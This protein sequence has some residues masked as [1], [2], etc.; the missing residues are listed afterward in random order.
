[1]QWNILYSEAIENIAEFLKTHLADVVCLQEMT[2]NYDKQ[3]F[4]HTPHYIAAQLGYHVYFQEITFM[5]KSMKLA[6]A[7][8]SKYPLS[9][10][11][12]VWI[13]KEQGSD[14]FDD[15]NR[16]YIQA[17]IDI[18]GKKITVGTVHMS[19]THEFKPTK[20]KLAEASKLTKAIE[21]T[22]TAFILTGDFNATPES[23]VINR[24]ERQLKNCGPEYTEKTWT[25][26]PFTYGGVNATTLDWRLDYI[27][28]SKDLKVDTTKVLQTEYSDHLPVYTNFS[29]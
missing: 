7:I 4:I 9:N 2:I 26:K 29:I 12:T 6:N 28:A 21:S 18:G 22:K 11:Q 25:T 27:F 16:A 10:T 1:M 5:H 13:N 15:E 14:T 8:F 3:K 23:E 19:Y 24:I 20:R 17:D